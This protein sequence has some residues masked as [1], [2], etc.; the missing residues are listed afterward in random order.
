MLRQVIGE[1]GTLIDDRV[2]SFAAYG[3]TDVSGD[4]VYLSEDVAY[5]IDE[6]AAAIVAW[7]PAEMRYSGR[8]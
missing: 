8:P 1:G 3:V 4:M 7:S 5:F 6:S 2:M